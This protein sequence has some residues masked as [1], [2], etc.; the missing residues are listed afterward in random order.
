MVKK[1]IIGV[2]CSLFLTWILWRVTGLMALSREIDG[3][4]FVGSPILAVIISI[5][6]VRSKLLESNRLE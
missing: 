5:L 6:L 2:L 4:V 3:I 1:I